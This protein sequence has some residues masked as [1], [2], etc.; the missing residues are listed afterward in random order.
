MAN[1]MQVWISIDWR[2]HP[3]AAVKT[4]REIENEVFEEAGRCG[5]LVVPGSWFLPDANDHKPEVFFRM[6][7]AASSPDNLTEAIRRLGLAIRT[8]FGIAKP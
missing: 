3:G 6:T 1:H 2:K 8:V 5:T 7:F 4:A